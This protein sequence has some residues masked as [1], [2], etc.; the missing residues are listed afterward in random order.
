MCNKAKMTI[1][2]KECASG[3]SATR[4][5][6]DRPIDD[7]RPIVVPTYSQ[8]AETEPKEV[9]V[10]N[11]SIEDLQSLKEQDPFLYYSIPGVRRAEL[12]SQEVD[13]SKLLV[14]DRS[15]RGSSCPTAR[16]EESE[17]S[18]SSTKVKRCTRLSFECH[19]DVLLEDFFLGELEETYDEKEME[20]LDL[21]LLKMFGL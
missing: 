6:D 20:R 14:D 17:A 16:H 9:D 4:S 7:D 8:E 10:G 15:G 19:T 12:H 5:V 18:T 2:A 11:L 1:A 3:S 21:E 13:M